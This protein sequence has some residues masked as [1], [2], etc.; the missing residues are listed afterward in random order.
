MMETNISRE[1]LIEDIRQLTD[2]IETAYP[3]PYFKGGGRIA[4]HRRLQ[5]LIRSIPAEGMTV[6]GFNFCLMPFL[7]SIKDGHTALLNDPTSLEHDD[8]GGI[9]LIFG[10]IEEKLYVRSVVR[11]AHKDLIGSLLVSVEGLSV[12][13]LIQRAKKF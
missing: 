13:E 5:K 4:Y 8:P 7:A 6:K 2:I 1:A 10:A 3:D 12:D 9:P 11:A